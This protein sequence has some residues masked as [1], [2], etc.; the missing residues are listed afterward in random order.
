MAK[1]KG[2]LDDL[3]DALGDAG[4]DMLGDLIEGLTGQS[5]SSSQADDL[6]E[7]L[8]G[9]GSSLLGGLGDVVSDLT[10]IGATN[11][12]ASEVAQMSDKVKV[13]AAPKKKVKSSGGKVKKETEGKKKTSSAKTSAAATLPLRQRRMGVLRQQRLTDQ[14]GEEPPPGE[15]PQNPL[16]RLAFL[17]HAAEPYGQLRVD[18]PPEER[19]LDHRGLGQG[20]G[21]RGEHHLRG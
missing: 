17:G 11:T 3:M 7:G 9:G 12:E 18:H 8:M 6:L 5:V 10:G 2:I 4:G 13:S 15:I 1:K 20:S 19:G 16:V 14:R 21:G